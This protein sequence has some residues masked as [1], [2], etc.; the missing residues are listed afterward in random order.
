MAEVQHGTKRGSTSRRV[1]VVL[2]LSLVAALTAIVILNLL[3]H[4]V[5]MHDF[6]TTVSLESVAVRGDSQGWVVGVAYGDG[7]S[8]F[9]QGTIQATTNGGAS[10][11]EQTSGTGWYPWAVT[12]ANAKCGWVVGEAALDSGGN[13][14]GGDVNEIL[15]TTNG[16]TTWAK[17]R[18][19]T[20]YNLVDVACAS[21]SRAWAVGGGKASDGVIVGTTNGGA[22]WE[23]QCLTTR[24]RLED[25]ALVDTRHGWAV[26]AGVILAT[27]DGGTTWDR[28][29]FVTRY[30]LTGV[31][32]ANDAKRAWAVGWD[33][34]S[35]HGTI[36]GTT[37]GGI[38]WKVEYSAS[39]VHLSKVAFADIAHGWAVGNSGTILTTTDGGN[40][41]TPQH[42]GTKMDLTGVAFANPGHGLVV[43][44]SFEGKDPL[45]AK[46]IGSIVLRTSDGGMTWRH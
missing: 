37:D 31:A 9:T 28:Q 5:L 38:T 23:R 12:F 17:Q 22:S 29:G 8:R 41:W 27:G 10:W 20:D 42:S 46:F 19:G 14:Q 30:D 15:A 45:S 13:P 3:Q 24:G 44:N 39:G 2:A 6:S 32:C 43:G 21:P 35:D 34:I 33:T 4:S 11:K 25:I 26:G 7:G 40:S 16:G 18:S 36:L 1:I